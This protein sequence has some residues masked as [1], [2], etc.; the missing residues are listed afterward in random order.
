M[1]RPRPVG[2]YGRAAGH[3][4]KPMLAPPVTS[5]AELSKL[6]PSKDGA[7]ELR[8]AKKP[9]KLSRI[10]P[11]ERLFD[12]PVGA[13]QPGEYDER[14]QD[15]EA[16]TTLGKFKPLTPDTS[17]ARICAAALPGKC[18]VEQIAEKARLRPDQVA[19]RL[20]YGLGVAHGI[21][22]QRDEKGV[23]T[24]ILPEGVPAEALVLK[25]AKVAKPAKAAKKPAATRGDSTP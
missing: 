5:Q 17:L 22:Y 6:R 18:T 1:R 4:R 25:A 21:G 15:S 12:S 9:K 2:S 16:A 3:R 11:K 20:R 23:I 8:S 13:P 24:L 10:N 14:R 19:H 7:A